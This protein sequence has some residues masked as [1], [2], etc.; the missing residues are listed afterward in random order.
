LFQP[1]NF[2]RVEH[3][4]HFPQMV[5]GSLADRVTVCT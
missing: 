1:T 5:L 3:E 4:V 2:V